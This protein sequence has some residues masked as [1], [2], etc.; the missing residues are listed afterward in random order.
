MIY[1]GID[2]GTTRAK[3]YVFDDGELKKG[4]SASF[5][6]IRNGSEETV[7]AGAILDAVISL[8]AQASRDYPTMAAVGITSFAEAFVLLDE[9]DR[10]LYDCML[11]SDP[12]GCQEAQEIGRDFD[13]GWLSSH[14]GNFANPMFSLPKLLYIKRHHP[15][16]YAKAVRFETIESYLVYMLS[17][18]SQVDYPLATR[19]LAF[20]IVTKTW[21]KEIL[22]KYGISDSLFPKLVDVGTIAGPIKRNLAVEKNLPLDLL[23][24]TGSH[25]QISA[26]LGVGAYEEGDA[27]DGIGTC[28]C[29]APLYTSAA[30]AKGMAL[31]G[32]G[33]VPYPKDGLFTCYGMV[34]TSGALFEWFTNTFYEG[35]SQ[36]EVFESLNHDVSEQPID[37][38]FSPHFAGSGT[39]N[40]TPD[41]QGAIV[42]LN[43]GTG[44]KQIYQALLESLSYEL[45]YNV[46]R[47]SEYGVT[48]KRLLVSG[49]GSKNDAYL[50][51]KA[52]IVG[53]PVVRFESSDAGVVGLGIMVG[54]AIGVFSS[55][56]DGISKMVKKRDVFMPKTTCEKSYQCHYEKYKTL[57]H[58]LR[59]WNGK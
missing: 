5:P 7:D 3:L 26:A 35:Q 16:V 42:N 10:C 59:A 6:E 9:K 17:G 27:S 30:N 21:N 36:K 46:E 34:K 53:I 49:G 20:D 1:A 54:K 47:L 56:E 15:D 18:V 2:V 8:I 29:I 58:A 22:A 44:K 19:T 4:Y 24:I 23:I 32:Y 31:D 39:P 57:F 40:M 28:E 55:L 25:D 37:V 48:I 50:Q 33:L 41:A 13:E 43:L 38:Y 11:Y 12:R 52:D 14:L 51:K 45:R